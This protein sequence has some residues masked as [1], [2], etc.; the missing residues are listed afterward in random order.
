MRVPLSRIAHTRSGDKGDTRNIGVIA[1]DKLCYPVLVHNVT[2]A[3]APGSIS[4]TC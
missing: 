2:A 4:A 1:S 3:R